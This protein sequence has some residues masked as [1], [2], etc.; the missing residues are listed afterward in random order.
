[1]TDRETKHTLSLSLLACGTGDN[2]TGNQDIKQTT[3]TSFSKP[4]LS[5]DGNDVCVCMSVIEVDHKIMAVFSRH[6]IRDC[7]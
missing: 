1:M 3:I 2:S 5:I 6:K 7:F 4:Y